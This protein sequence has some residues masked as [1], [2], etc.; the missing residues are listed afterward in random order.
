M[1]RSPLKRSDKPMKRSEIQRKP[2]KSKSKPKSAG[3]FS[4]SV[5]EVIYERDCGRC[6][7][8]GKPLEWGMGNTQ[9]RQAR[10]SGGAKHNDRKGWPSNGILLDAACHEHVERNPEE[11]ARLGYRV[12]QGA[13]PLK[14]PVLYYDGVWRTLRSDGTRTYDP[15]EL[16][17]RWGVDGNRV[18]PVD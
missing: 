14:V 11:A 9:H 13:D 7:R 4:L 5:K 12:G 1:R 2:M 18:R 6:V 15:L 10:G 17:P 3:D 8:C 16:A